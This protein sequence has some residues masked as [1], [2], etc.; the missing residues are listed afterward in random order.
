M[1]KTILWITVT[2]IGAY[3]ALVLIVFVLQKKMIFHPN[4]TLSYDPG[5]IGLDYEEVSIRTEDNVTL[6]GWYIP[7]EKSRGTVLFMHGNAGDIGDR[8]DTIL[9]LHRLKLNQFIFDYRGYGRSDGSPSE[10]GLYRDARAA[11]DYL[12]DRKKIDT[13]RLIIMGRSLGGAVAAWLAAH[14]SCRVV[15]LEST[16]TSAP[17]V[18]ADIY[19][20]L[21]GRYMIRYRFP[22]KKWVQKL[23]VPILIAHSVD[24]KLIPY[25]HGQE[26][27]RAAHPPKKF[28]KLN[29]QHASAFM[30]TGDKY[31]QTMGDFLK[32]HLPPE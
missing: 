24:D 16:F 27:Y 7:H 10:K 1:L 19:P 14:V 31:G 20:Y 18:A 30:D 22:V 29:G 21:P 11:Y 2:L 17:D 32:K 5:A 8:M 28:L 23:R 12:R 25:E 9:Q 13:D 6:H 3:T 26:L 15:I 4:R